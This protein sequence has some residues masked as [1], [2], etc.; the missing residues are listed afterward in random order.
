MQAFGQEVTERK[1]YYKYLGR[2]RSVGIKTNLKAAFSIGSFMFCIYGYYAYAFYWGTYLITERKE[3]T[4]YSDNRIYSAGDV[5]SCFFGIIFGVFSLG[6]AT[7][8][9]KAVVEGTIAGKLAYDIINRK[10]DIL[11]DD[12]NAKRVEN[13]KG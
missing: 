4:S 10:P 11:I 6:A 8:N 9:I 12:P 7:P 3:N 13:L 2:A 1:N 5:M